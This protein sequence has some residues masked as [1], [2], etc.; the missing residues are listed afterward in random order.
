[1]RRERK[2]ATQLRLLD[3]V[4]VLGGSTKFP[5]NEKNT[6]IQ[7]TQN[8]II[9]NSIKRRIENEK[10][11]CFEDL[12]LYQRKARISVNLDYSLC[13]TY[14]SWMQRTEPVPAIF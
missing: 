4:C 6:T 3:S 11:V 8:A 1:M 14:Y 7:E 10:E 12:E 5:F 9:S 2:G 13:L